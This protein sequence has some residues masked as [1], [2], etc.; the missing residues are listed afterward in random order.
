MPAQHW[1]SEIFFEPYPGT[2][3]VVVSVQD[4]LTLTEPGA[5]T[6]SCSTYDGS[7]SRARLT[8][9]KVGAIHE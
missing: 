7:A 1:Y 6:L 8:A 9:I 5:A 4:V 3:E 2:A